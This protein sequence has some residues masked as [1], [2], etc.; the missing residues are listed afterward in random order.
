MD[1]EK[2]ITNWLDVNKER[3]QTCSCKADLIVPKIKT[4]KNA[5]YVDVD[6]K[7]CLARITIWDSGECDR[8]VLDAKTGERILYEYL[9][10]NNLTELQKLLEVFFQ[11]IRCL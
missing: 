11:K 10:F 6:S 5:V 2:E 1:I 8:E 7:N 3:I 9:Y 4:D